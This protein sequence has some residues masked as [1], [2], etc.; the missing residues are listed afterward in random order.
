MSL[1]NGLLTYFSDIYIVSLQNKGEILEKKERKASRDGILA[2]FQFYIGDKSEEIFEGM[3]IN[4]SP[5]SLGFLTK[6]SVKE[7]QTITI[8]KLA[9]KSTMPDFTGQRAKVIWVKRGPRYDEAGAN[10]NSDS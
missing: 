3:T 7:G 6:T 1:L 5:R 4:I 9:R 2:D 8:T 10:F